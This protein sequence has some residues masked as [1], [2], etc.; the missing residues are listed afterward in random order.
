[1]Q[2]EVTE[3]RRSISYAD[4][5]L[6]L[7]ADVVELQGRIDAAAKEVCEELADM[8]PEIRGPEPSCI[9]DAIESAKEEMQKA[10]AAAIS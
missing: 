10:I 8:F 6:T 2:Y 9:R 1:M 7:Q 4:L 5:D 3:V